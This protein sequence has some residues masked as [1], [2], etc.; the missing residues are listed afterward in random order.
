MKISTILK[1][2]DKG[3]SFE[4]FPP[5]TEEA[6]SQ[7]RSVVSGLSRYDPL[8]ASVT[9]G[10]GGSTQ[11]RTR[12]T[13]L[14]LKKETGLTLMSHLTCIGATKEGM[15]ALLR[16]Y[17]ENGID[18][19]LALRG[20]LPHDI[21]E[22]DRTLGDFRYAIDLVRFIKNYDYFS[23]A[24]AVYPEGH[25]EARSLDE[26]LRHAK[27][28]IDDAGADFAITQMFF[29]NA[30]FYD[31]MDRAGKIGITIPVLPG[32]MPITDLEKTKKFASFCKATVPASIEKEMIPFIGKPEEM[33]KKGVEL[34]VR[35]CEDLLRNGVKYLHFYTLNRAEAA[36][37]ILRALKI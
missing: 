14:M 3:V 22:A 33:F 21:Y 28:K 9:Y 32:I 35:Q 29:D 13:L 19:I 7:F 18:N 11:E 1:E 12:D 5:K 25:Q 6:K 20:D 23:M 4:F 27:E 15:D 10:A 34:A 26:D 8:Y 31:F 2:K 37:E 17:M 36:G 16:D 30:Y 24:V